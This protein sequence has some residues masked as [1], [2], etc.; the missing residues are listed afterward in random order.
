MK[1]SHVVFVAAAAMLQATTLKA[2]QAPPECAGAGRV[3]F[4]A[5]LDI[6]VMAHVCS[7]VAPETGASFDRVLARYRDDNP[8]CFAAT[9][10][11]PQLKEQ[12]NAPSIAKLVADFR[13]GTMASAQREALVQSCRTIEASDRKTRASD[14]AYR[15]LVQKTRAAEATPAK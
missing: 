6:S 13:S 12:T 1:V 11:M 15:E 3:V 5:T 8:S 4:S 7:Q 14:D 10:Q 9:R 2:Q